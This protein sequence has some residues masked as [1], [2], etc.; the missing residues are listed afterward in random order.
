MRSSFF[1]L[2]E[3]A[4]ILTG[5]YASSPGD[6]FGAFLLKHRNLITLK[7]IVIADGMG[8]DHVSVSHERRCPSWD[9][10]CWV[11]HLFFE[12]NECVVQYH[13]PASDYVNVH[14]NCLH[15][16]RPADGV[17]PMPPVGCV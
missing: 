3:K 12:P 5:L 14:P 9:E 11:K 17:L 8:W 2:V 4:R 1:P 6:L 10:M 15:L 16:W 7:A 13:P